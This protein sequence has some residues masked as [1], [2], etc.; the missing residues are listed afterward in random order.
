MSNYID[1]VL[2]RAEKATP[3]PWF[4]AYEYTSI[5]TR[6][7]QLGATGCCTSEGPGWFSIDLDG[8]CLGGE[9][10]A[11]AGFIAHA[12]TDVPELARRLKRAIREMRLS[13]DEELYRIADELEAPLDEK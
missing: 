13:I 8:D 7:P 2:A 5:V 12:R 9:S 10:S 6:G 1:E 11:N 4:Y 3:G